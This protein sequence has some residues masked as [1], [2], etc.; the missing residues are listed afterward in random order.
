MEKNQYTQ[1]LDALEQHYTNAD[2]W[3]DDKR[4]SSADDVDTDLNDGLANGDAGDS[5]EIADNADQAMGSV[6]IP[7]YDNLATTPM[8]E[9]GGKRVSNVSCFS[10][11][12]WIFTFMGSAIYQDTG[13]ST[14]DDS[15]QE[16]ACG[17][18]L[19]ENGLRLTCIKAL[20]YY[21]LPQNA[22][23]RGT[24]SYS[25][26]API[27]PIAKWLARLFAR[28]DLYIDP[29]GTGQYRTINDLN[30]SHVEQFLK[31]DLPSPYIRYAVARLIRDWRH[32]SITGYLPADFHLA[33]EVI[34][35]ATFKRLWEEVQHARRPYLPLSLDTFAALVS[36]AATWVEEY[37]RPII[38]AYNILLPVL[39]Q[40]AAD[41]IAI[42]TFSWDQALIDLRALQGRYPRV[43]DLGWNNDIYV[44]NRKKK[45]WSRCPTQH[46]A[47]F[48]H[49]VSGE[50]ENRMCRPCAR[51]ER[52]AQERS[53]V[54]E[55]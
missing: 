10:D 31:E 21:H 40:A 11:T 23:F 29:H 14:W 36:G 52:R 5:T 48:L 9:W 39:A 38:T 28:Y 37:A 43:Q 54:S 55:S 45:E 22:I 49:D 19:P 13:R 42:K 2:D 17:L 34:D 1:T 6:E 7:K 35:D 46:S 32:L 15:G 12:R 3:D 4:L 16:G 53:T 20:V 25:S 44:V 30:R 33:F 41:P 47:R 50:A 27:V 24:R 26:V 51:N 18:L 8:Q